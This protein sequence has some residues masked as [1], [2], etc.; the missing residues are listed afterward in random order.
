MIQ[1]EDI[2]RQ[3]RL[4]E[5]SQWEFKRIEFR[6]NIPI[7]PRRDDLADELGAFGKCGRRDNAL[8]SV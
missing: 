4:G 6:G 3:L 8:R 7:S 5:D 1:D 2:R